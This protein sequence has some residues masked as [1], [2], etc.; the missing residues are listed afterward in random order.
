MEVFAPGRYLAR[1]ARRR[2]PQN[3]GHPRELVSTVTLPSVG[4]LDNAGSPRNAPGVFRVKDLTR[5]FLA[6]LAVAVNAGTTEPATLRWYQDQLR[7]LDHVGDV[8]ADALRTHHLAA[9]ELTNGFARAL[10]R[11]YKWAA[12]EQLVPRDPFVKLAT[13]PAGQRERV[14]TR[15]EVARLY[16]ASPRPLRR[17]LFVQLRTIARPGEIR[18]LTWGQVDLDRRVITLIKFK[19]KKRRR[20]KLKARVIPLPVVVVM[21]LR[22]LLRKSIDPSPAGRVFYS[23]GRPWSA[24]AVRCAMRRARRRAGLDDGEEPVVCYHLRHTGAT[25]AIRAEVPLKLVAEVMGHARTSTTERYLHLDAG[26]LVGA[27]DRASRRQKPA[28]NPPHP[29]DDRP[30]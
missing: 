6:D 27:I 11:L 20:D 1:P 25:N 24:N 8:P 19:G 5:S 17:L 13:P 22:N 7:H 12:V 28:S 26:D 9:I 3:C 16:L 2:R 23:N 29:P 14:L 21:L 10:K 15:A 4:E 30:T 18:G